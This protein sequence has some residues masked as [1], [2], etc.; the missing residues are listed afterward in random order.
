VAERVFRR[1]DGTAIPASFSGAALRDEKGSIRGF[2]CVAQDL[3]ERKEMEEQ[4][5]DSLSQKELLLR[6][7]HHRVKNNLQVISSLLDLQSRTIT[8]P[9]ALDRFKESQ[10]RIRS[11]AYVH[12]QLYHGSHVEKIDFR[13]YL[14]RLTEHLIQSY[15]VAPAQIGTKLTVEEVNLDLDRALACGLIVN[16]LVTNAFKHGFPEGLAGEVEISSRFAQNGDCILEVSDNGRGFN[17]DLDPEKTESL[18]LSLVRT[19]VKQLRG[20]LEINRGDK[21]S[22]RIE[23]PLDFP[24]EVA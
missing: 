16:E 17:Q 18:G 6:E 12:E 4:L 11:I 3:T 2:V 22:F 10:D 13:M 14:K 24:Q 1:K 9:E 23:F 19:L 8:E 7:V 15:E 20:R 21:V 5:R